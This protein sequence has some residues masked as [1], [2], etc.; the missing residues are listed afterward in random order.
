VADSALDL[1]G[2]TLLVAIAGLVG[3]AAGIGN[4]YKAWTCEFMSELGAGTPQVA[5]W[6]GRAGYAA[7][8]VVFGLIG[9]QI[10][11]LAIGGGRQDLGMES[12]L[13]ELRSRDWLFPMVALGLGAFGLFSLIMARY[14]RIE[15][16]RRP[17]I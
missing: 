2:G 9:W 14:A 12:A 4:F 11:S 10:L 13:E 3:I 15:E 1:P 16:A 5:R 6:A 8:G 7:R 17:A